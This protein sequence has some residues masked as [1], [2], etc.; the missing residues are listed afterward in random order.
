MITLNLLSPEE[1]KI[2]LAEQTNRRIIFWGVNLVT[3]LLIFII[4]LSFIYVSI[5]I[6]SKIAETDFKN[7]QAKFKI[8]G[9]QNLQTEIKQMNAQIKNLDKIQT[10]HKYYS[11][12]LEKIIDIIPVN[13]LIKKISINQ[14]QVTVE[15]FSPSRET[16]LLIRQNLEKSPLFEKIESPIANLLKPT[17]IDFRFSFTLKK[18]SLEYK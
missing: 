5:S 8:E 13:A 9:L 12:A 1:K 4:L 10:E 7:A 11:Q 15:G 6:K 2:I 3:A 16:V 14:N 18:E 17:D